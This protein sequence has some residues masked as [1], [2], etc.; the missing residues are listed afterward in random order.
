MAAHTRSP[1]HRA[2]LSREVTAPRAAR[3]ALERW[4]GPCLETSDLDLVKLLTS[5]LVANA[6][7]HGTGEITML[8][9][10]DADRVNV[11]VMDQ[12]KGFEHDRRY[13]GF[14]DVGGRGLKIVDAEA[15]RWGIRRGASH[16]W[17]DVER[18]GA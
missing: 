17:F 2:S 18:S 14:D 4:F 11:E 16:V 1:V 13:R 9:R 6:V 10:L 8:A 7:V 5:E 12:G 3:R 15:E